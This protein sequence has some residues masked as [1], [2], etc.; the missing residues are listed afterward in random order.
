MF[1]NLSKGSVLYGLD[2]RGEVKLFTASVERVTPPLAKNMQTTFGQLPELVVDITAIVN[3]ERK[4]FKQVPSNNAIAD[5]G[6]DTFVLADNKD[7]LVNYV[8]ATLQ[9]SRNIVNSV[10]KHKK[11]IS[12][13]ETILSELN[14][15]P[16]NDS[17]VRQLKEQVTA[18]Q[19]QLA[20]AL[21]LLK[22][23]N[24]NKNNSH[25]SNV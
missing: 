8:N 17:A 10:D 23:T 9:T 5:F 2:T 13:Y 4:E 22:G 16:A 7:S 18:L 25:G 24:A 15:N 11:L 21:S 14:P 12:Q 3:G 20:E 6:P 1:S 19:G